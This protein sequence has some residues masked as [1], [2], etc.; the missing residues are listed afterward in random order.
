MALSETSHKKDPYFFEIVYKSRLKTSGMN[1]TH[2]LSH[3]FTQKTDTDS[4]SPFPTLQDSFP[5]NSDE[6]ATRNVAERRAEHPIPSIRPARGTS[7]RI[8]GCKIIIVNQEA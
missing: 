6:E 7:R 5:S 2:L 8:S 4:E 3:S 1:H